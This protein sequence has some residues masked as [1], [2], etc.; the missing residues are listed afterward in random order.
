MARTTHLNALQALD[1]ALREGSLQRAADKLGITPAAVGQRIRALE[2][3][4]ETDLILRGR[5]GLQA[6]PALQ[7]ALDDLRLAFDALDR[8]SDTLDFQRTSEIHIVGDPDWVDLWLSPRLPSFRA[9]YPNIFF[10]ANGEGDV[11]MRLGAADIIVDRDPNGRTASGE[12]LYHEVFLPVGSPENVGRVQDPHSAKTDDGSPRYLPVGQLSSREG[13]WQHSQK[14]GLE[15]F[16]LLHI[17]P[18]S[19]APDIPGWAD[20]L[21]RYPYERTSP[22]RGVQYSLERNALDGVR[23][24]AGLLICGLSCIIDDLHRGDLS[25]IFPARESLKAKHPY[26][27]KVREETKTRPQVLRFLEWLHGEVAK[28]K[29]AMQAVLNADA[30]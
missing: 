11:P 18:R 27:I 12:I 5:S 2:Q 14:G 7:S 16:P 28:T 10:N 30:L 17:K 4:L 8:V 15:G 24:N 23:S 20:W 6:T 29:T 26:R 9:E 22:E 21:H 13:M 3:F 1:M 19:D 25:L